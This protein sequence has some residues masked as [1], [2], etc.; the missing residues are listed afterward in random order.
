MTLVIGP[1]DGLGLEGVPWLDVGLVGVTSHVG[2]GGD[3]TVGAQDPE[4]SDECPTI[5]MELAW[6]MFI[7]VRSSFSK[8][9]KESRNCGFSNRVMYIKVNFWGGGMELSRHMG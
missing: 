3:T 7:M 4:G 9:L 8:V 2:R 5:R 1:L 6:A